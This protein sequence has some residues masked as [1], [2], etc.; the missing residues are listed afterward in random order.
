MTVREGDRLDSREADGLCPILV[1]LVAV[2][3]DFEVVRALLLTVALP[4]RCAVGDRSDLEKESEQ[5]RVCQTE[6]D[7]LCDDVVDL[8]LDT[9]AD[10]STV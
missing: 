4:E 3:A 10:R 6:S 2:V 5:E 1:D 9:V 7:E 8:E